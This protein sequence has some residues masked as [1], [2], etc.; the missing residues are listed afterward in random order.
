MQKATSMQSYS[1]I[2]DKTWVDNKIYLYKMLT[3]NL[4]QAMLV[5]KAE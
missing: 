4:L 1:M 3:T 2:Y 5:R